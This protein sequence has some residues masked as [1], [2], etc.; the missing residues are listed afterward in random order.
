MHTAVWPA[1]R[2]AL[3]K[4]VVAG[5][6]TPAAQPW[7]E[8]SARAPLAGHVEF[9]GYVSAEARQAT[10]AGALALVMPSHHEG[11]GIPALEAMTLGVPV[12]VANRGA[13]PEV[14]GNASLTFDPA[15]A[16]ELAR[17]LSRVIDEPALRSSMR[18]RGFLRAAQYD[19]RGM[20]T[21]ARE[22]WAL[23]IEAKRRAG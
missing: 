7:I 4:L 17:A 20:A 6:A 8:Q 10:Y 23:A 15:N 2:D 12:I 16:D 11:F 21:A 5:R 1:T 19:A 22:A 13:L 3:P 18:D 9:R 14:T